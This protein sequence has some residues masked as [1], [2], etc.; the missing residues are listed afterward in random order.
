M[1]QFLS[2]FKPHLKLFIA[3]MFFATFI[4]GIDLF[5]PVLTRY[6]INELLPKNSYKFFFILITSIFILYLMR[7]GA[8]Y[9][10]TYIGHVFGTHVETDMRR[11]I[12][13]HIEKQSFTFFDTHRTG[14]LMSNITNDLFEISELAHHGPEDLFISSVTLIGSFIIM[15]KIRWELAL[16]VFLFIPIIIFHTTVSRHRLMKTSK[17]VKE[18]KAEINAAL[19]SSISG[20]RVT[21]VF[22]NETFENQRFD[23]SNHAYFSAKKG[24]YKDMAFFHSRMEFLTSILNVIVLCIGGYLIMKGKMNLADLIAANLFI[25]AFSQPIRRI[26]NFVEQFTTGM[27]GYN[28][29]K[30]ILDFDDQTESNPGAITLT[31]AKGNISYENVAF[32]YNNGVTVLK[33]INLNIEAGKTI[34]LVGPSGGGKTTLCQLLPRFYELKSGRITL[35]GINTKD[36][37]VESLRKQI[38]LVQQDV[39]LFAG[40]I[41]ENIA[42]G[43]IDATEEEIIN[44]TKRAEIHEDILKMPQGYDTVVGERGIRL[45]GGQKQRVSI[46]RV[47]L[48]NPPILILDEATS[49]LD[50]ATE[51][52]IQHSFEELSKG[53]TTLVIA[54]R[55]ST[56]QNADLIAVINEEGITE[57]GTHTQLL[58][59]KGQYAALQEAQY[60]LLD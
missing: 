47:F 56:I 45:S 3:D 36:I 28:R 54:H 5:F 19:E 23:T 55:L 4:A 29:F 8:S 57:I 44:A 33:D 38:G 46:A 40:S 43:K 24:Y 41:R 50:T 27:A 20:I 16:V 12:F 26:T 7:T 1:K 10:V 6:T 15:L 18:Q 34:A 11:D 32:A 53:R 58:A 30:E 37:T 25:S 17:Q 39:F 31:T 60:G 35:D 9:F 49:A 51:I 48:K 2:Y 52:K 14:H 59:K 13:H 22:T 21:K 42:Y